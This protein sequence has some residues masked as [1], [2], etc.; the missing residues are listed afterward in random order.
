[1]PDA[2]MTVMAAWIAFN[3]MLATMLGLALLAKRGTSSRRP[4]RDDDDGDAPEE[5]L[6]EGTARQKGA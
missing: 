4:G 3:A 1:M 6:Y 2:M 5:A